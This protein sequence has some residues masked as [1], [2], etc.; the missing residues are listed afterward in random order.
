MNDFAKQKPAREIKQKLMTQSYTWKLVSATG[1]KQKG[2]FCL[3]EV[4]ILGYYFRICA[5]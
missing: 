5:Y 3:S 2:F 1:I 4:K